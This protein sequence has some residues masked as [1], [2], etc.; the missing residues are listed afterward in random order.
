MKKIIGIT[1]AVLEECLE[2]V[3]VKSRV[4]APGGRTFPMSRQVPQARPASERRS[5]RYARVH[6]SCS[7]RIGEVCGW[8]VGVVVG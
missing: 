7:G 8:F 4:E 3:D 2:P 6:G 5:G 1:A